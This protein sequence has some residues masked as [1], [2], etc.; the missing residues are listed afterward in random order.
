[1]NNAQ[2]TNTSAFSSASQAIAPDLQTCNVVLV[3]RAPPHLATT[4][5]LQWPGRT[6]IVVEILSGCVRNSQRWLYIMEGHSQD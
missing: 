1:M 4:P 2:N 6:P 5:M 3:A